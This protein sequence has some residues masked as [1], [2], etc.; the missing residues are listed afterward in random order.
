MPVTKEQTYTNGNYT[1]QIKGKIRVLVN[2]T[3]YVDR[4][5]NRSVE[6]SEAEEPKNCITRRVV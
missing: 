3:E 5:I 1:L 2:V 4:K 6:I